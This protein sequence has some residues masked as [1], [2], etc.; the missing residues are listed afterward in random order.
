MFRPH[1][2]PAAF[3]IGQKRGSITGGEGQIHRRSFALGLSLGLKEIG[4]AVDE[5]EAVAAASPQGEHRAEQDRAIAAEDNRKLA[6]I[7]D[8]NDG[9]SEDR[10]PGSDRMRVQD[11]GLGIRRYIL[12]RD[13]QPSGVTGK[14][15]LAKPDLQEPVGQTLDAVRRQAER[16]GRFKDG[17]GP[18][19]HRRASLV[20]GD[21]PLASCNVQT[22][23]LD[24][25]RQQ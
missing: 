12:R 7:E 18:G 23:E 11:M 17:V 24:R 8:R 21:D 15:A 22:S 10:R 19:L 25:G 13:R 6:R 4:M 16:G 9:V 14:K 1:Q 2:R 5:E 3:Q 20:D